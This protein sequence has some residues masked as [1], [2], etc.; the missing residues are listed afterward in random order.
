MSFLPIA[1][2]IRRSFAPLKITRDSSL[3]LAIPIVYTLFRSLLWGAG[4]IPGMESAGGD[5]SVRS[6]P[7][8]V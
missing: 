6:L 5:Y 8:A 4:N 2:V 1:N 3:L 7:L